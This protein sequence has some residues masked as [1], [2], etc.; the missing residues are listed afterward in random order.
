METAF[1]D[2][3]T[4]FVQH[5]P[6]TDPGVFGP[7]FEE[8]P[9]ELTNLCQMVQGFLLHVFWAE[10]YGVASA[11]IRREEAGIRHVE[12]MLARGLA[13]DSTPLAAP[14]P[15]EKRLIGNCRNFSL[16][17]CSQLRHQG[18]PARVRCGFAKYFL[19]GHHEDHWV[20][21]YWLEAESRWVL[22]DAQL[23]PLQ[24][25]ALKISFDPLDVPRDQFLVAGRAWQLCRHKEADPE[26]FGIFDMHGLWFVRGNLIRDI[27]ALNKMPLLPWD[28]WGLIDRRDEDLAEE[29][30]SLLD[31]IAGA[32]AAEIDYQRVRKVYS[33]NDRLRV[34]QVIN[35]YTEK[36][37][38]QVEVATETPIR[39][40]AK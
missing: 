31:N 14:R 7:Q 19:A 5:G 11:D 6:I 3:G 35:S 15:P 22:V 33:A 29:D 27:A 30:L 40:L 28:R 13:I 25:Q 18:V 34:P 21:E 16:L 26:T 32:S 17:L 4:Y 24:C 10:K 9:R 37:M 20:C 39:Q 1:M 38:I 8:L 2:P 36:G 23:D 12:R